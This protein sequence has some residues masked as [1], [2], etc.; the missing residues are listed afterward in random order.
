MEL[1]RLSEIVIVVDPAVIGWTVSTL[2]RRFSETILVGEDP[3][4][5]VPPYA[6]SVIVTV[7][8]A[9]DGLAKDSVLGDAESGPTV[10]AGVGVADPTIAVSEAVAPYL[11]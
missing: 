1:P 8:D 3:M 2:P 4:V 10:G 6:V 9:D 7:C 5:H 11:S